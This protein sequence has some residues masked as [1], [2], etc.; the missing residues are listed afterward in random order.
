M[1]LQRGP[2]DA[3]K[4][5]QHTKKSLEGEAFWRNLGGAP[6]PE[7]TRMRLKLGECLEVRI[8]QDV[9]AAVVS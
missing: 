6:L 1:V 3:A 5:Q 8:E 9:P 7:G 2:M 4:Y